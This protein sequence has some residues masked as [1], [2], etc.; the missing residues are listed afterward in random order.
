MFQNTSTLSTVLWLTEFLLKKKPTVRMG[1]AGKSV[2]L[3]NKSESLFKFQSR[4]SK[5]TTSKGVTNAFS[6]AAA[7]L[8]KS[9]PRLCVQEKKNLEELASTFGAAS[10]Y[11]RLRFGTRV[12]RQVKL[13]SCSVELSRQ[14]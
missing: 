14:L 9:G 2:C 7:S 13:I 8:F 6:S 10:G 4:T 5:R 3:V 12:I 1:G 11:G